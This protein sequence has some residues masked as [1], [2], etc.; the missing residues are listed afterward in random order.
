HTIGDAACSRFVLTQAHPR[1]FRI[2][3]QA[4]RNES[5]C[6]HAVSAG[7][8]GMDHPKIVVTDV[9][10]LRTTCDFADGPDARRRGLQPLIHFDISSSRSFD[11]SELKSDSPSVRG[12]T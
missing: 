1:K 2:G 10:E 5:S 7:E 8:A 4:K 11:T 9:C 12:A 3:K 6:R